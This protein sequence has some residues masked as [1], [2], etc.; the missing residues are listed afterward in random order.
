M[1]R[2]WVWR[3]EPLYNFLFYLIPYSHVSAFAIQVMEVEDH[4]HFISSMLFEIS[5]V[6]FSVCFA[7]SL[8]F[9]EIATLAFAES[10]GTTVRQR[11]LVNW[12]GGLRTLFVFNSRLG[13][14]SYDH[15]DLLVYQII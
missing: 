7:S 13:S 15:P 9:T 4:E 5:F 3:G 1:V 11:K 10:G 14:L 6:F 2:R 12:M 8:I